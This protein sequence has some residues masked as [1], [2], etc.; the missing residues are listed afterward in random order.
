M[1]EQACREQV[2]PGPRERRIRKQ[3]QSS[4]E[5]GIEL[6]EGLLEECT[7]G[8]TSKMAATSD[9]YRQRG[10]ILEERS[11]KG[12]SKMAAPMFNIDDAV[13]L[14]SDDEGDDPIFDVWPS[15]SRGASASLE[16]VEEELLDYDK[17]VEEHVVSVPRGDS[18]ETP[19][20]VQ[21][22]VQGD[23][24]GGR[25]RELVAGNLPRGEEGVLVSVGFGGGREG[26]GDAIQKIGKGICG[27]AKEQRKRSVDASIQLSLVQ[28]TGAG[29]SE[30][31]LGLGSEVVQKSGF[32]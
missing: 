3:A 2:R 30:M 25:C 4:F 11:L 17:E 15:T 29:K 31:S 9:S 8:G 19:R 5:R 14:I 18:M 21:K 26:F 6:S 27:V 7:L 20:V 22:V 24:F 28:D 12:A 16:R 10:S 1:R 13:V 32:G 23:H